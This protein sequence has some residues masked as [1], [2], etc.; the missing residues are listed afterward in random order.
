MPHML[1]VKEIDEINIGAKFNRIAV[2]FA[3]PAIIQVCCFVD[4]LSPPVKDDKLEIFFDN[5]ESKNTKFPVFCITIR[6]ERIREIKAVIG[7][8]S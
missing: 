3:V 5:A 2:V 6:G 8:Y 4:Q 7:L 1:G